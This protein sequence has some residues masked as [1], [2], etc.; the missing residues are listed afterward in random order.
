MN[1]LYGLITVWSFPCLTFVIIVYP[2]DIRSDFKQKIASQLLLILWPRLPFPWMTKLRAYFQL[3]V[4][5]NHYTIIK[6]MWES[7]FNMNSQTF[8]EFTKKGKKK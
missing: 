8:L 1:F 5:S 2:V 4:G 3:R 6:L 7:L